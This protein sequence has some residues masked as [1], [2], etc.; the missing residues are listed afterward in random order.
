[1]APVVVRGDQFLHPLVELAVTLGH[2]VAK[3][4]TMPSAPTVVATTGTQ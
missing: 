4:S 2:Q 3:V 1:M